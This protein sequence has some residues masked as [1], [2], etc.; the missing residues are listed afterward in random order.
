MPTGFSHSSGEEADDRRQ[1]TAEAAQQ[2][3]VRAPAESAH[4]EVRFREAE[5]RFHDLVDWFDD[6]YFEVDLKGTFT[7]VN[8]AYCRIVGRSAHELVG[9]KLEHLGQGTNRAK[10]IEA[11]FSTVPLEAQDWALIALATAIML[12]KEEMTKRFW[13]AGQMD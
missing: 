4:V 11:M 10:D 1:D 7:F 13:K 8:E 5:A 3:P 2:R 6:G 12:L 9:S